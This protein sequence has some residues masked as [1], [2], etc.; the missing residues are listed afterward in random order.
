MWFIGQNVTKTLDI[1]EKVFILQNVRRI[2]CAI[3]LG[4]N[5]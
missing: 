2:Y 5:V 1:Q 3:E 4:E